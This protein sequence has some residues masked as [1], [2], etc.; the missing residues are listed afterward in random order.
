MR[1]FAVALMSV[2]LSGCAKPDNMRTP[3]AVT[4][5]LESIINTTPEATVAV[6]IRDAT[7]ALNVD[8]RADRTFHAASTMKIAVMVEAYRRAQQ[9][10]LA[11]DSTLEVKNRFR[12]IADDSWYSI[13]DDSDDA[14]YERL[15]E[16]MTFRELIY[17]MMT[18]S[19]NLATNLLIDTLSADSIQRTVDRLGASGLRVLRGVEDLKA[20]ERG[21]SNRTTA[22][23][24]ADL[25]LRLQQGTAVSQEADSAMVQIMLHSVFDEMIPAGMPEG[26]QVANKT[27]WIT[28]I[29]HDAGLILPPDSPPYVLVILMEGVDDA[30][31]SAAL[32]ARLAR[33]IHAALRPLQP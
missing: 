24:L 33:E 27:G 23:A 29:H 10:T 18:V 1:C 28:R 11:L 22:R 2:A 25:L 13:E 31:V 32:G 5:A 15:G 14:I 30:Q 9:E 4:L 6:A 26:V 16:R 20:F 8:L 19:S 12:S 21:Q 3:E 17:Q 7:S